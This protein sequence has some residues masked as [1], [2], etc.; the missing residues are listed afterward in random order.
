MDVQVISPDSIMQKVATGKPYTLLFSIAA[1]DAPEDKDLATSLQMGHLAYLF[2]LEQQGHIS[3]FGPVIDDVRL[4]G[5]TV[6]TTT[7][8]EHIKALMADDPYIKGGYLTYELLDW[9]SIPGL[10]LPG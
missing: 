10:T 7:D 5:I 2:T 3:I 4:R 1:M 9:F 8:K 6:F